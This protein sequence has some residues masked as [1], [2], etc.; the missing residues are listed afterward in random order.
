[1]GVGLA[2]VF[3][4]ADMESEQLAFDDFG[5]YPG[6]FFLY[7]LV[8]GDG[9]VG[10]LL[11]RFRVLQ[12]GVVAGH[13]RAERAPA[14]AI[15]RLIEATERSAQSGDAGK[16]IFFRNGAIAEGEAGSDGGAQ[17]PFAVDVPGFEAGRPFFNQEAADF[18]V[19]GFGPDDSDIGER[20]AGDPHF[21]AVE[22]VL[23][24]LFHGAGEHAAGIGAEL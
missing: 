23:I 16:K 3:P 18:F 24:A 5:D 11:A 9:L 13:S 8:R 7:E 14:D 20:T 15:A 6:Q 2:L 10:E 17:G 19:F 4:A 21:F 22:D 12:R 1:R